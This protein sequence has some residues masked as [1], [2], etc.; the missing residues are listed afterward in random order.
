ME[1]TKATWT[2]GGILTWTKQYFSEKGVDNPRLDAEVLL[3]HILG[4]DRI[5]LYVNF[6]QPLQPTE[7]TAFRAAVKQ[8]AMRLP[9]AYITGCKEFMGLDFSVSPAVLIPRP[10]TEFLVEAA[11]DRL[12]KINK[13]IVLDIGTGS[14]AI[15]I[16]VLAK[17]PSACGAAV[18]ISKSALAVAA[19]NAQHN[20]VADR[21]V[22][23]QGDLFSPVHG[24]LFDAIL[25]NPPYIP[26]EDILQLEPEVQREPKLAL[27]G[28][29]DGL[30][31]YRRII[32][33]GRQFLKPGGF[34][35][36]EIGI[37]QAEA[38][39]QLAEKSEGFKVAELIKD[40]AGIDRVVVLEQ[41]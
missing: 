7:L 20:G 5:H 25:S 24:Q 8:R 11:L 19:N 4:K 37:G 13:P 9:V 17:N 22:F 10:D 39:T 36:V 27:A 41:R 21:V 6:D 23:Y 34:I 29:R 16:S 2:I 30:D 12:E 40:Y 15:I 31:Y 1:T 18:D 26:N 14:G 35:A 3:S 32:N 38:V 33:Q 28:G